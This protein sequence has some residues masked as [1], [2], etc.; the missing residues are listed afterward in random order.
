[1]L[2]MCGVRV[3]VPSAWNRAACG[4]VLLRLEEVDAVDETGD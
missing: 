1:M 4:V 2:S 3:S